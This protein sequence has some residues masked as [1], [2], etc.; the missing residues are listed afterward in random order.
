[1]GDPV[2][3][4]V[5]PEIVSG[6][7]LEEVVLA[8]KDVVIPIDPRSGESGIEDLLDRNRERFGKEEELLEA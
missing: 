7:G 5:E 3:G 2:S 6:N 4:I 8:W 1:M